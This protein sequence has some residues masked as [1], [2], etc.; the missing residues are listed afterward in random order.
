MVNQTLFVIGS[1]GSAGPEPKNHKNGPGAKAQ[2]HSRSLKATTDAG[3]LP[4]DV[5]QRPGW[6][7]QKEQDER[8][9]PSQSP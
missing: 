4:F 2:E 5:S 8:T 9:D 1:P 6:V 3:R 7:S